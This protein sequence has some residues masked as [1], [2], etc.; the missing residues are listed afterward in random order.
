MKKILFLPIVLISLFSCKKDNQVKPLANTPITINGGCENSYK[1]YSC[2][3]TTTEGCYVKNINAF[4]IGITNGIVTEN[5][6]I[7]VTLQ[8]PLC[9]NKLTIFSS[10]SLAPKPLCGVE[11]WDTLNNCAPD[12]LYGEDFSNKDTSMVVISK[13]GN[14]GELVQGTYYS[15]LKDISGGTINKILISGSFSII[16][17]ADRP[18]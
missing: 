18:Y 1:N 17:T 2:D 3:L 15:I 7:K 9:S 16:R 5:G 6:T 11:V 8:F 13:F 4:H 10:R 14:V 12:V